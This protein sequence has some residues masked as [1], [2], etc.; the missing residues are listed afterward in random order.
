MNEAASFVHGGADPFLAARAT[1]DDPRLGGEADRLNHPPYKIA[2]ENADLTKNAIFPS[3]LHAN[4][5]HE[6]ECVPAELQMLIC[7]A[8]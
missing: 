6:Y 8:H 3:V 5:L 7:V 4:G 1:W 2:T